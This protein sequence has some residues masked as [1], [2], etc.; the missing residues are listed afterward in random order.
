MLK[1]NYRNTD[2]ILGF[3]YRFAC[4]YLS[5][6]DKDEDHVPLVVPESAGRHGTQPAVKTFESYEQEARYIAH[7]F[8]R[9]HDE[10][11]IS[12]SD[13]CVTYRNNWMGEK[14]HKAFLV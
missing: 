13:M 2:E 3:A 4:R 7:I 8:H 14:L 9:L 10:Q 11:G 12:W 1:L 5:P 6:D